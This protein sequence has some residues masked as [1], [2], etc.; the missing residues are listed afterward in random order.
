MDKIL[1]RI[2]GSSDQALTDFIIYKV[3]LVEQLGLQLPKYDVIDIF[4][5]FVRDELCAMI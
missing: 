4:A 2:L 1:R 3:N 5:G